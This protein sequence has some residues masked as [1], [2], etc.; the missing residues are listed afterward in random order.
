[1]DRYHSDDKQQSTLTILVSEIQVCFFQ[2][3]NRPKMG[4]LP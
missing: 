2:D 3:G 1:M 4:H